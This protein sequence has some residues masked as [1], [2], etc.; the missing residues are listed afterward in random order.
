MDCPEMKGM[1][2]AAFAEVA[3]YFRVL[4][5]PLRL[6][7]LDALR[8][9]ELSVGQVCETVSSSQANVSKHLQ[10]LLDAGLVARR[11]KGTSAIYS[12]ADPFIFTL[13]EQVC[14]QLGERLQAQAEKRA[15]WFI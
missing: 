1:S 11:T 13:C 12:I 5:E 14:D 15:A 2:D 4:S 7:I 9:G 6:K 3:N 10:I 8:A